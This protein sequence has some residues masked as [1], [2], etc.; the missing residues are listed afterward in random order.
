MLSYL[1]HRL[2]S[3]NW[4]EGRNKLARFHENFSS[5]DSMVRTKLG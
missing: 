3:M 4:R 1:D 2:G 5:R